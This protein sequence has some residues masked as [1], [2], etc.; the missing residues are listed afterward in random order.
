MLGVAEFALVNFCV[1]HHLR[2]IDQAQLDARDELAYQC[3]VENGLRQIAL[4][5][6]FEVA[7]VI[8]IVFDW[9]ASIDALIV[10]PALYYGGVALRLRG[11]GS[12][13]RGG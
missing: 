8:V 3:L 6:S 12:G 13:D 1:G 11:D 9:R 7:L 2:R 5:H 4:P 10:H